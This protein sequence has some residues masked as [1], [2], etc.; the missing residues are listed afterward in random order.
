MAALLRPALFGLL[1]V[2]AALVG[3]STSDEALGISLVWPLYGV[4]VLWIASGSRAT[5]PWDTLGLGVLTGATILVDTGDPALVVVSVLLVVL[6]SWTWVLVTGWLQPGRSALSRPRTLWDLVVVLTASAASALLG[7]VLRTW[8][9]GLL[10]TYDLETFLLLMVRNCSGILG[11]V[12]VGVLLLPYLRSGGRA[13]VR[14]VLAERADAPGRWV[15][16]VV[17]MLALAAFLVREVFFS[18]AAAPMAFTLVLL[19]VWASFRVPPVAAVALALVIGTAGVVASLRDRGQLEDFGG[20]PFTAA[21]TA[22]AFLITLVLAALAIAI[23]VEERRRATERARSA[24]QVAEARAALFSTVVEHLDEGVTVI[25][26][27]DDYTLRNRAAQRLTGLGGF[28][29][30][31][32][33]D[34][35]Q[36]QMLDD[37]GVPIPVPEMPHSRARA[38]GRV[39]RETVRLRSPS[40]VERRV[41]ISSIPIP[42]LGEDQRPV[43]VNTLRDVTAGHEERDQLVS[44][45]GVVAHDLKNPLT[46][47]RGWSESLQEELASDAPPDVAALRSMVARV[48]NAS[49]QMRSFIDDLLGITVARDRRLELETVDLSALAEEVAELRRAGDTLPR[50][51]V[52]PGMWVTGDRFL[53]RQL[54]DNLVGNAVKYVAS[55]VRPAV[56]VTA[57]TVDGQLEVAVSDNGIGIPADQRE[58]IFDSFV[59]AHAEGYTGT[60]LGL[61]ICQRVVDRHGGRIRADEAP[62]GG[63]R[64]SF[65]LPIAQRPAEPVADV[66]A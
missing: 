53:V 41:E 7:A 37:A 60:G 50:I 4:G 16:E 54:L 28:L 19:V 49:D 55:G 56:V 57:R 12:S 52:Q 40:G 32:P 63:T 3:R 65:T 22:Q 35:G 36:P 34:A 51:S 15:V 64:I 48:V 42:G 14:R 61:A 39:V 45:A 2:L 33:D 31:D 23:D 5:R 58:R 11:P 9:L 44:F 17:V 59:R 38:E 46:V 24:E 18:G 10:P 21:A 43:V 20:E 6:T 26:S 27:D 8:G 47:I 66:P 13:E 25:T 29:R 1:T 62:G 30:P